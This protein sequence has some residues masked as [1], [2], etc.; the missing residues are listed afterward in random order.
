LSQGTHHLYI[1]SKENPW[2]M[3]MVSSFLV[4]S[5]LPV[6][7]LYLKGAITSNGSLIEWATAQESNTD[8]FIV[9]YSVD[10]ITYKS[11]GELKAAGSSSTSLK[12]SFLHL[13]PAG[14][15][16][17][18]RIRQVDKDGRFTHSRI[19]TLLQQNGIVKATLSPNPAANMLNVAE[20][21][22]VNIRQVQVHDRQGKLVFQQA[23]NLTG[24]TVFSIPVSQLPAGYY[25]LTLHTDKEIQT[26]P[27]VK[28]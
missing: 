18:Y 1:R 16:N 14:G 25:V 22:P 6:S 23:Y 15:F 12:Y 13:H 7:W 28:Q 8:K 2:S 17:Y 10:G 19:V 27:F 3:T 20:P 26:L 11:V 5:T 9:E 4:G 21:S 24:V